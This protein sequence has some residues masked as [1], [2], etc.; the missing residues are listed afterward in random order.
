VIFTFCSVLI[1]GIGQANC[2]NLN[3]P[4]ISLDNSGSSSAGGDDDDKPQ[5]LYA[6]VWKHL[7]IIIFI[8][9]YFYLYLFIFI[10]IYLYLFIF[11]YIYLYLY[12]FTHYGPQKDHKLTVC[13]SNVVPSIFLVSSGKRYP[14]VNTFTANKRT[15]DMP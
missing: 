3:G 10:Y 2:S 8:Y 1:N 5:G 9:Y 7:F 14:V 4:L 15:F 11:I 6:D 12:C 13:D